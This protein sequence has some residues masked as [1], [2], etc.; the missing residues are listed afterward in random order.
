MNRFGK[1]DRRYIVN[2]I[3]ARCFEAAFN[4]RGMARQRQQSYKQRLDIP[5]AL[6]PHTPSPGYTTLQSSGTTADLASRS[7]FSKTLSINRVGIQRDSIVFDL[8]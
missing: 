8:V 3:A 7:T 4:F 5:D 1:S 6:E 2:G